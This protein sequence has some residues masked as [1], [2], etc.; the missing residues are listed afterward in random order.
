[1]F[2]KLIRIIFLF[3]IGVVSPH[4]VASHTTVIGSTSAEF[5]VANGAVDYS[6]PI[7]VASGRAGIQP[8]ISLNYA[9]GRENGVLG[10]G[11]KLGGLSII[12][13][14]TATFNCSS[15]SAPKPISC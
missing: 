9:G 15:E 10:V 13:R 12:H 8:S 14:C 11:W 1:M 3:I 6:I 4:V 2:Y 5:D 7:K